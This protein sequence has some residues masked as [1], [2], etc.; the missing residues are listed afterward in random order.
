MSFFRRLLQLSDDNKVTIAIILQ[1]FISLIG[2]DIYTFI[3]NLF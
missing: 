2:H 1:P 3:K